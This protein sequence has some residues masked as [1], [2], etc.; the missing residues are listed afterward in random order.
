M[1]I[2]KQV[3]AGFNRGAETYTQAAHLQ[4]KV[5]KNLSHQLHD[6]MAEKILEI[7]C[8]T[9][10]LTQHLLKVFPQADFLLTDI[11]S[12]MIEQ[13][14][15]QVMEFSKVKLA[16]MDGE[17]LNLLSS[18]DLIVSSM[19]LHWFKELESSLIRIKQKL[20]KGG[21]LLFSML[22]E[23][24]LCEWR[25]MCRHFKYQIATPIFPS[26]PQ[27]KDQF[28]E[29]NWQVETIKE[30]Y[31]SAHAF[32]RTLKFL[33]ATAARAGYLPL[34]ADKMRQLIHYFNHE[35]EIT[36]EVIYG[37]YQAP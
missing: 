3:I 35:I 21:R 24:S 17:Q 33:G 4:V 14:R 26:L 36:Y 8:G 2:K 5:A 18:F 37:E 34:T 22:S 9:G 6:A 30:I 32:L 10:L 20:Q 23:N 12:S 11:S 19:T 7:G 31:P 27:L 1:I 16:C 13:C 28:P 25:D 29:F 15:Q